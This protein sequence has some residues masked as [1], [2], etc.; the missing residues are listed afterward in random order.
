MR[1]LVVEDNHD[2]RVAVI[3]SLRK[4]GLVLDGVA[5]LPAADAALG[6]HHYH[7]T[8]FDR[9]LPSGDALEYVAARRGAGWSA[10]VLF[11]TGRSGVVDRVEGLR[12]ADDYLSKPFAMPE[13]VA[14]VRNLCRRGDRVTA[15][16]LR[17]EDLEVDL[18]RR[19]VRRAG[20]L[21]TLGRKEFEVLEQLMIAQPSTV[22]RQALVA[23][24][25]DEGTEVSSNVLDV[26]IAGL[27][28]KLGDPPLVRT[29]RG[30]G[31]RV[32]TAG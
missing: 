24:C 2:L 4:A 15:T 14:R 30:V 21:L 6:L 9:A 3:A 12:H 16:V 11:L 23:G 18:G 28:R 5:D 25:W 20:V 7:C 1:V 17:C 22:T 27:R 26:T 13:L 8:V 31:Y 10:P 29:I 19:A 32:D